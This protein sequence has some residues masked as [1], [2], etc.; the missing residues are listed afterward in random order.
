[1]LHV[2]LNFFIRGFLFERMEK[3]L[4]CSACS[5]PIEVIYKQLSGKKCSCEGLCKNC[6]L[7]KQR[8]EGDVGPLDHKDC[9]SIQC[10][11]CNTSLSDVLHGEPLGCAHC[12][13][14]FEAA[15]CQRLLCEKLEYKQD[16]MTNKKDAP[17]SDQLLKLSKDLQEA[18]LNENYE[19]A[20]L[21]RDEMMKL[22]KLMGE[23]G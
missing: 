11:E 3:P 9:K 10:E 22:K 12:Y 18:V 8:L 17:T 21:I 1:M 23:N 20:A 5:L 14:V 13:E 15:I 4:E 6:P 16:V 19:R 2:P 7:L